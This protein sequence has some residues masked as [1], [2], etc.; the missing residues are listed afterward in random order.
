MRALS[1]RVI[2]ASRK[3]IWLLFSS[4][5]VTEM[6][7]SILL[8]VL[9]KES[10][11]FLLMMQKLSS[12]YRFHALGGVGVVSMAISSIA[13]M[14]KIGKHR[15]NGAAHGTAMDLFINTVVVDEIVVG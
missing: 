10:N 8:S 13:S 7:L 6:C 2:K 12:T 3:A 5:M 11:A 1:L 4:S 15:T 9:W 14:H